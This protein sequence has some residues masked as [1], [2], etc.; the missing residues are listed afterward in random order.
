MVTGRNGRILAAAQNTEDIT[1]H[2]HRWE[3]GVF[4]TSLSLEGVEA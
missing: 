2:E 3:K 4:T 1:A